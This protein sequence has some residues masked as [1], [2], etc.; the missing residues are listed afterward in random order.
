MALFFAASTIGPGQLL[1]ELQMGA[2]L[3]ASGCIVAV[4]VGRVLR[5]GRFARRPQVTHQ[6]QSRRRTS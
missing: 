1:A 4:A 5:V 3:S 2:L 6:N